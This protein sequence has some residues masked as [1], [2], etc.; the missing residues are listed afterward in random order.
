MLRI[1]VNSIVSTGHAGETIFVLK[2]EKKSQNVRRDFSFFRL[3]EMFTIWA[4]D[5]R[6]VF[7]KHNNIIDYTERSKINRLL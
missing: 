1:F 7:E 4:A 6:L 3:V 2:K 5:E